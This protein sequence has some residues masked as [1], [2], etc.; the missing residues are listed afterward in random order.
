MCVCARKNIITQTHRDMYMYVESN[1]NNNNNEVIGLDWI[2]LDG[3]LCEISHASSTQGRTEKQRD[4][5]EIR[6]FNF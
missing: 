6:G 4:G 5:S 1:N 3:M 2:G